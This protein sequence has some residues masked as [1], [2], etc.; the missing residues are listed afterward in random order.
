VDRLKRKRLGMLKRRA[1]VKKKLRFA[2]ERLRLSVFRSNKHIYAQIV[3]PVAGKALMGA[4]TLSK[5]L[6][7]DNSKGKEDISKRV[8]QL[9][10]GMALK[11]GIKKVVFDKNG[12]LYHGRVKALADGAREAG[13]VF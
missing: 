11:D 8:G 1:R 10:A 7:G 6:S 12:F 5:K 13:L 4:S 3:D 9:I 2:N